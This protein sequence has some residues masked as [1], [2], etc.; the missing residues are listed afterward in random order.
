MPLGVD[1]DANQQVLPALDGRNLQGVFIT[2]I[3]VAEHFRSHTE[4]RGERRRV[5]ITYPA[6]L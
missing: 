4:T 5:T 1:Q 2:L 3:V 6:V